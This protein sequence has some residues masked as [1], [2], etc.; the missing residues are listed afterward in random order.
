M[1]PVVP[2]QPVKGVIKET[3]VLGN[4]DDYEDE[5]FDNDEEENFKVRL[6]VS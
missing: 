1:N 5:D 6:T 3:F 4:D 2:A